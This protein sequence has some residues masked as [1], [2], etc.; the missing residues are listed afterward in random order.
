MNAAAWSPGTVV[1]VIAAVIV[2]ALVA[3][4]IAMTRMPFERRARF[5]RFLG[6]AFLVL[7]GVATI[8]G[9]VAQF[10]K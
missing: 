8:A 7:I 10:V 1:A 4:G 9:M 3:F 6:H 5:A 2:V